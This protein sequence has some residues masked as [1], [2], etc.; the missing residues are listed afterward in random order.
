MEQDE[1]YRWHSALAWFGT[2]L[3]CSVWL[4][5]SGVVLL[6]RDSA[7]AG[8]IL[9][10]IYLALAILAAAFWLRRETVTAYRALQVWFAAM[11]LL[12]LMAMATLQWTGTYTKV[13][14][15][16]WGMVFLWIGVG[17][18]GPL[19]ILDFYARHKTNGRGNFFGVLFDLIASFF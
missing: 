9:A 3:G 18:G 8:F 7:A 13:N 11:W 19:L 16:A 6:A 4:G 14:L 2:T 17:L 12:S 1:Y 5:I 10:G 15:D